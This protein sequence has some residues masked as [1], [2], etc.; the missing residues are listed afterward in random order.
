MSQR[1]G[2]LKDKTDFGLQLAYD[3]DSEKTDSTSEIG[4]ANDTPEQDRQSDEVG[5]KLDLARAYIDMGDVEGAR[6]I[7]DE[8]M[9]E[10][11]EEQ[12]DQA[13]AMIGKI[14]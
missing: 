12:R 6:E 2:S 8:V 9:S 14:A 11:S 1:V 3:A 10:G 7:L 13:N 5:T 4:E